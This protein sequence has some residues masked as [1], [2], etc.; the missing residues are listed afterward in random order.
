MEKLKYWLAAARL[1][2]LP[3]SVSGIIVGSS[4]SGFINQQF[5]QVLAIQTNDYYIFFGALLTTIVFQ[6][7]S[8]FAN[9]YGDGV[10][11]TDAFRKGEARMVS[12]GKISSKQMKSA[13]ILFA[14]IGLFLTINLVLYAF[15]GYNLGYV[16]LFLGLGVGSI[17]AAIK[18][19]IGNNAYGYSGFGDIF[20]FVFFGLLSVCGSYFL[21]TKTLNFYIFLPA[22]S[23]GM[24]S[25]AV[26]N[27]NNMRDIEN[28]K[29]NN[30]ITLAVKKGYDW[31][32]QYHFVLVITPLISSCIYVFFNFESLTQF[33]FVMAFIP[34]FFH[35]KK[36][37]F[38]KN[39]QLLDGEL[40]KVALS[41]F[42]YA[43]LFSI[44]N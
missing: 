22:L 18:Y 2:T 1:R 32:K 33:V 36:I 31:A 20:V 14:L 40:K 28:D 6:I 42:L 39:P 44:F 19:T 41:T 13:T 30:K 15:N 21:Y 8:N 34:L 5:N 23:I 27:L 17:I 37:T 3:L 7:L 12:S 24:L 26:L 43:I 29:N 10:K 4:L 16:F 9:D 35:L 11:G 25:V 38:N